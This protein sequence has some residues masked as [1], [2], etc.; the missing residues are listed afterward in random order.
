M[1]LKKALRPLIFLMVFSLSACTL[2][3]SAPPAPTPIDPAAVLTQ[4]AQMVFS[5]MT[6]TAQ[7]WTPTPQ[8]TETPIPSPTAIASPAPL[9]SPFPTLAPFLTGTPALT[10]LPTFGAPIEQPTSLAVGCNNSEYAGYTNPPRGVVVKPGQQFL[11]IWRLK[12]IGT[13]TWDEGYRLAYAGGDGNMGAAPFVI[14]NK[15]DFVKPGEVKDLGVTLTAP[16]V[17]KDYGSCWRMQDDQGNFFGVTVCA[18]FT[19]KK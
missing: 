11:K 13:C 8:P 6:Q 16:N 10:A 5:A 1:I 9:G 2:G 7:A 14:Q 3:Q 18:W 15:N 4:A 17:E 19:V 12:N